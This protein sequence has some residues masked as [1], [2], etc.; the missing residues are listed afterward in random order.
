MEYLKVIDIMLKMLFLTMLSLLLSF[1]LIAFELT[2]YEKY[3][4]YSKYTVEQKFEFKDENSKKKIAVKASN[5]KTY[6]VDAS[7]MKIKYKFADKKHP[8]GTKTPL[9][10][11]VPEM[12]IDAPKYMVGS[13]K[14]EI[15]DKPAKLSQTFYK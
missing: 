11:E 6:Y 5:G 9:I 14:G 12:K 1:V 8:A 10:I 3:I 13:I 7:Q 4:T 15:K 2:D